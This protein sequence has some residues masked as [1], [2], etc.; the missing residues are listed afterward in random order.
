[1]SKKQKIV[2]SQTLLKHQQKHLTQYAQELKQLQTDIETNDALSIK[3][4]KVA[5]NLV[6]KAG[7]ILIEAKKLVKHGG[8]EKWVSANVPTISKR[9]SENYMRLAKKAAN[10][11]YVAL[12]TD[13]E[14]LRQAYLRVGIINSTPATEQRADGQPGPE[15][16]TPDVRCNCTAEYLAQCHACQQFLIA[17][18]WH[19]KRIRELARYRCR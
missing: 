14:N 19:S 17:K 18:Q 9:T 5:L 8:W 4:G 2:S 7:G 13:A 6:I 11:Q 12:L 1:M 16:S 15:Q 3:H 10:P